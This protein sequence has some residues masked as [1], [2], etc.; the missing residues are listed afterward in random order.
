MTS[1]IFDLHGQH[2]HQSL[3]QLENHRKVLDRFGECETKTEEYRRQFLELKSL[4][5][6]YSKILSTERE[7]LRQI[8][9]LKHAISEIQ[10]AALKPK[11]DEEIDQEH[12]LL[13]NH[14][15]LFQLLEHIYRDISENRGGALASIRSARTAMDELVEIDSN[16]STQKNQLEDSFYELEDFIEGVRHFKDQVKFDPQR[17]AEVEERLALIR[18][19]K[20][21]YGNTIEEV[22]AFCQ[23][24]KQ[25]IEAIEN[26][27]EDKE[28]LKKD[29]AEREKSILKLAEEI[30]QIRKKA[31]S[32]LEKRAED[33][34]KQLGMPKVRFKVLVKD[35][36]NQ[37]QK[38]IIGVYGKDDIEFLISPNLGEPFKK[39]RSVASGGELSR[40]MLALKSALSESDNISSLIFDEVDT[41]IGG[42][43]SLAVGERLKYLSTFKQIL[44]ITHLA[45]IAVRADNHIRVEKVIEKARTFT[46][47]KNIMGKEQV[48]EIARMLAGDKEENISI[49][50][51][52]ELI[53]KYG[54]KG[55]TVYGKN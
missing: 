38:P 36:L 28:I 53:T 15:R 46:K 10:E 12:K 40:V 35:R 45:T 44:C 18:M 3:L 8:D 27:E 11:E 22:L 5:D 21:K 6:R 2:E 49:K 13:A 14:E 32:V 31:A 34:L 16:L 29:I 1:L 25:E 54:S 47:V 9:I 51:A 20:K 55:G 26:W 52:Q 48:E 37:K 43:I 4:K 7:R 17:L 33:E 19:L 39:L 23:E 50:H 30:S 24:S 41:G 42:E